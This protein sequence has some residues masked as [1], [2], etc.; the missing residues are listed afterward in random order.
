MLSLHYLDTIVQTGH[1]SHCLSFK[2]GLIGKALF[3]YIHAKQSGEVHYKKYAESLMQI[4]FEDVSMNMPITFMEGLSGIGWCIQYL[5]SNH[6]EEGD[7]NEILEDLDN[8]IMEHNPLRM[9]DI[10]FENGLAGIVAYIRARLDSQGSFVPFDE[11]YLKSLQEACIKCRLDFYS[12]DYEMDNIYKRILQYYASLQENE[13]M[14]WETGLLLL[15]Q[16]LSEVKENTNNSYVE[17]L[18]FET[19]LRLSNKPCVLLFTQTSRAASYGIGTYVKQMAQCLASAKWDVCIFELDCPTEDVG[20]GIV[21]GAG[22][23][24]L[25]QQ[26]VKG[27]SREY[28]YA[29][30]VI[31]HF[32]WKYGHIICH[33][34]FAVYPLMVER[35]RSN[36]H[37]KSV[38]TLHFTSWSFNLSGDKEHLMQILE[39]QHDN[40]EKY[41]YK[42]FVEEKEFMLKY[43]DRVIAIAQHSYDMI[44]YF[45]GIPKEKLS[46]V[47][48]GCTFPKTLRNKKRGLALRQKYGFKMSDKI[49]VFCGRLDSIKGIV[50]LI[51]AF[52]VLSNEMNDIRL[53]VIGEGNFKSCF[54]FA[55]GL[56]NKI[57][58][59]GFLKKDKI[60]EFYEMADYG[61]VPSIH[62]EFGYVAL[63]MMMAGLPIIANNTTGLKNITENGKYGLLYNHER[64]LEEDGF[65]AVVKKA[66]LGQ[67]TIPRADT[68]VLKDKY[69]IEA[70]RK[71]ILEVY[72][73]I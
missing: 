36:L 6:R 52:R 9:R 14:P 12:K 20:F 23:Y 5:I 25:S 42:T 70:F 62:E 37:A 73:S 60:M 11:D 58:F 34:N 53:V 50:N 31:Q 21:D 59:T 16:V 27:I 13:R 46:L 29:Q 38:Y 40:R 28:N 57:T 65:L 72:N 3:F 8:A 63:E 48:N 10:S 1:D 47:L 18:N 39:Q 45:Y 24:K 17:Q 4:L 33:F 68:N 26:G 64:A 51:D 67:I 61:V 32:Y 7:A 56:W 44:H 71:N 41:I 66:L 49:M 69:S 2:R 54:K 22:Y 15:E 35:L 19:R 43:C 30:L 55:D